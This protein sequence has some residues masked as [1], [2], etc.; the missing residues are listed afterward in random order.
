MK[1]SRIEILSFV[2]FLLIVILSLNGCK[3]V[4]ETKSEDL[5]KNKETIGNNIG[6]KKVEIISINEENHGDF[7]L[8]IDRVIPLETNSN[9]LLGEFFRKVEFYNNQFFLHEELESK[10]IFSFDQFGKFRF[11]FNKGKGPGEILSIH[12]FSFL[13]D[14]LVLV[15][16]R[17][18]KYF[19][20]DGNY[21]G[22]W[23]VPDDFYISN[24]IQFKSNLFV[25]GKFPAKTA[26]KSWDR[27]NPEEF[28]GNNITLY[29]VYDSNFKEEL[30]Y[31]VPISRE[32]S[33]S[34]NYTH[35]YK[36]EDHIIMLSPPSNNIYIYDGDEHYL[37]YTLDFGRKNFNN[38]E[39][40]LGSNN[41]FKMIRKKERWG[42]LDNILETK[43]Y[44]SVG[45]LKGIGIPS[46][47][48][49]SKKTKKFAYFENIF[50]KEKL[51]DVL[52]LNANGDQFICLIKPFDLSDER[53]QLLTERFSLS[54]PITENSNP[55]IIF[56]TV[57]EN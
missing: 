49:F 51:N 2:G 26:F 42:S 37:A 12:G 41:Y 25:Y 6:V 32:Y 39:I 15:D 33:P 13:N 46:F 4:E 54:E 35:F 8:N 23:S 20:L 7:S 18:H 16:G 34:S 29:K 56:A 53:R 48:I 5:T 22:E 57:K 21:I 27:K 17:E 40:D 14:T 47:C 52:V 24:F 11:K 1:L 28:Y 30:D 45:F 31:F 38:K 9:C 50:E 10:N 43:D 55:V 19:D 44:I 36:Y 3:N